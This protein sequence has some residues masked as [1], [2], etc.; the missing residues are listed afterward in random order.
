VRATLDL[1]EASTTVYRQ[2][3]R[4]IVPSS[5]IFPLPK[6]S[7]IRMLCNLHSPTRPRYPY[8]AKMAD[9]KSSLNHI[10]LH[11]PNYPIP[12][13]PKIADPG[14]RGKAQE[15][16]QLVLKM[17]RENESW[18]YTRVKCANPM[19]SCLRRAHRRHWPSD[20]LRYHGRM[21]EV[22]RLSQLPP[23]GHVRGLVLLLDLTNQLVFLEEQQHGTAQ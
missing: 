6:M 12:R 2:S 17:V 15:I 8:T 22:R 21:S 1:Q 9:N 20:R 7:D 4:S 16:V 3:S 23:R 19:A 5:T 13:H 14:Y 18:G 10:R 11:T